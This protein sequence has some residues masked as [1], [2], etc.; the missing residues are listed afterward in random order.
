MT[1]NEQVND[2]EV[3]LFKPARIR[4][5]IEKDKQGVYPDKNKVRRILPLEPKPAEPDSR[6]GSASSCGNGS[7]ETGSRSQRPCPVACATLVARK[8]LAGASPKAPATYWS[9]FELR[10]YQ[11]EA[12]AALEKYWSRGGGNPLVVMA[13][14]TGKSV[15][16]AH[17]IRDISRVIRLCGSWS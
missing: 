10:P 11:P 15:I 3:F 5:G 7:A 13:T 16:I 17:L 6:P 14:A 9:M 1:I 8:D 2:A 4:L 12:L